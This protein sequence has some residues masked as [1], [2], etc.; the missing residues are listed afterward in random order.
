MVYIDEMKRIF[1][2]K[3]VDQH[4]DSRWKCHA[5]KQSV[6]KIPQLKQIKYDWIMLLMHNLPLVW[7]IFFMWL[8][9]D[10]ISGT[11]SLL[12]SFFFANIMKGLCLFTVF[13]FRLFVY[14]YLIFSLLM[15][16]LT[17]ISIWHCPTVM[18]RIVDGISKD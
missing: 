9:L 13:F 4:S 17:R 16:S 10:C 2:H 14:F 5:K 1:K 7:I 12:L 3:C 6:P 18:C 8:P 15:Q 11:Q